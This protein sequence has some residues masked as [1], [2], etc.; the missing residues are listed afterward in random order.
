MPQ[1]VAIVG[2]GYIAVELAGIFLHLGA[3]VTMFIRHSEF[4]RTFDDII[5]TTVMEEYVKQGMTFVTCANITKVENE[6]TKED[7][8]LRVFAERNAGGGASA[9]TAASVIEEHDGFE[10]IVFAVG[11]IPNTEPL[12]LP[13]TGINVDQDGYIVVDEWQNTSVEGV[14]ALGDVCGVAPLTPAAIAA[15]RKLS[16]RLFGGIKDA[17]LDYTNIPSVIFSHPACGSVGLTEAEAR[18]KYGNEAIKI[19]SSRFT[20]MYYSMCGEFKM[21]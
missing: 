1:K 13:S 15:G 16:E 6:G 9:A 17:K 20:N 2:A 10:E 18:E 19:Y 7:K 3:K 21:E 5:R 8:R 12:N 14:Y 4:L 11:R